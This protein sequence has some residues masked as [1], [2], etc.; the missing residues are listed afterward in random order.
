M[1]K[2]INMIL[3]IKL[4]WC[5]CKN[6]PKYSAINNSIIISEKRQKEKDKD[7][8]KGKEKANKIFSLFY[9][10][11]SRSSIMQWWQGTE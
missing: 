8:G 9:C 7:K 3:R 2:T 11:F 6:V 4:C 1:N 10:I 5:C